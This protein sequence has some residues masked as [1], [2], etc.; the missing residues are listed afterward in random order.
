MQLGQMKKYKL[1]AGKPCKLEKGDII[2]IALTK[3]LVS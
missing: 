2:Y 1:A 3:L